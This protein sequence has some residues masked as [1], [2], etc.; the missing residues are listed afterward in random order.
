MRRRRKTI[1]QMTIRIKHLKLTVYTLRR[2]AEGESE[3]LPIESNIRVNMSTLLVKCSMQ[4]TH[5]DAEVGD[6]LY[7]CTEIQ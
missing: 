1:I 5:L 6:T 2:A 4:P 3:R 7:R